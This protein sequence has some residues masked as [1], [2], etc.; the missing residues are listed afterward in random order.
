MPSAPGTEQMS[1]AFRNVLHLLTRQQ[2]PP[3]SF[4]G[5]GNDTA[6]SDTAEPQTEQAA[7]W[8]NRTAR[9]WRPCEHQ[10]DKTQRLVFSPGRWRPLLQRL[11]WFTVKHISRSEL[12]SRKSYFC[13]LVTRF[14]STDIG[15]CWCVFSW[16]AEEKHL[17]S[18][19]ASRRENWFLMDS[20]RHCD[21]F[22]FV[23]TL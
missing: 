22:L 2:C 14:L 18:D 17:F 23:E 6:V 5:G 13:Y 21:R 7:A 12:Q 3:S 11:Q 19:S 4:C 1:R 20:F 16:N 10:L 15:Q 9:W 8:D